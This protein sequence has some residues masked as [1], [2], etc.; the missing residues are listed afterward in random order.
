MVRPSAPRR[1]RTAVRREL[2]LRP[3]VE[4][5]EKRR[6][7]ATITV[8]G[9]GDAI[10][11]TDGQVTLREAITA[12]NGNK[13][14][15]DVVG[16]GAYGADT[17]AFNIPGAG[18]HT[19]RPT[20]ALPQITDPVT[21]D[22]YTQPGSAPNT[23]PVGQGL[24]GALLIE[25][26]GENAGDVP[27]GMIEF[28]TTDSTVRGLVI[29]RTQGVKI[30]ITN[31]GAVGHIRIEGNY[32]GTDA[33]G[34]AGFAA[35]SNPN[36]FARD[37][38]FVRTVGNTIGGT[39]PA[40][41]NLISGNIG[42][43][44][45]SYGV[46]VNAPVPLGIGTFIQGNL[47]GT[48]RTGTVALGNG[49][50]GVRGGSAFDG[51]GPLI[52]GGPEV[53]AGNLISGNGGAG[54]RI[55]NGVVQGNSIGTDITGASPLG[56]DTGVQAFGN[57]RIEQNI[58]AFNMLIAGVDNTGDGNL[59]TRNSI[60]SN[61]GPGI[62][63]NAYQNDAPPDADGI[64]NY[65]LLGSASVN[66]TGTRV[67]GTLAS[68]PSSSFRLEFFASAEREEN[69][70]EA[71]NGVFGEG[72]TF[73]GT[74]D[75]T[76]D[77]TG[78]AT[79]TADLPALPAGQPYVTATAT[80][81]TDDGAGPRNNTSPFSPIAVLGGSSFVVTNT[82]DT[83][84]GSLREA[85]DNANL[86]A[87]AQTITFAIPATD[88]H[89]V[90]YRIDG[91]SGAVTT[92]DI[93]ITTATD[94]AQ[95]ADIDPDW[96]HSWYSIRLD[97]DLPKIVD[98]IVIDGYSQPGSMRNTLPA[99]GDLDT[100]LRI[101]LDGT[102]APGNGLEL[103]FLNG[104]IDA[105][106]SQ[107]D[108]L[109]I[110]R[111]GGDGIVLDTLN[112]GNTIAGS[113]IG[114]DISGLLDRGNGGNGVALS[115]EDGATIGG[116]A[117][118]SRNL[119]SGNALSGID[120]LQTTRGLVEGNLL[121]TGRS[122]TTALPNGGDAIYFHSAVG[123]SGFQSETMSQ[124]RGA[125]DQ[126]EADKV[127]EIRRDYFR[128]INHWVRSYDTDYDPFK[129]TKMALA[130]DEGNPFTHDENGQAIDLGKPG[131]TPND[132]DNP[133]TPEID[134]D[135]DDGP[136][137]LQNYPVLT[138]ATTTR[139]STT[140]AGSLNSHVN[141]S[142]RLEFYSSSY[143]TNLFRA[144][145]H[146]LGFMDVRTDASGNASFVFTSPTL[147]P[148]GWNV[149]SLATRL[150]TGTLKPIETS[151]FSAGVAVA[152]AA[153]QALANLSVSQ[154]ATPN[155]APVGGDLIFT[156][157]V[158]NAGPGPASGVRLVVAPPA[159]ATFVA[160]T[161]GVAPAGGTLTFDLGALANGAS[162]TVTVVVRPLTP[163]TYTTSAVV[164]ASEPD[165]TPGD[166][167]SSLAVAAVDR[168]GPTIVA[169]ARFGK[170]S[171][172]TGLILTFSEALAA[173][174]AANLAGYRLLTP[175][176][177][178]KY[179]TRDDVRVRLKSAAYDAATRR[180]T[181]LTK[182]KAVLPTKFRLVVDGATGTG[183]TD[184]AGNYLDGNADGRPSD[185]FIRDLTRRSLAAPIS[186]VAAASV[187]S[188]RR[189]AQLGSQPATGFLRVRYTH[190]NL[191]LRTHNRK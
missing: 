7:L 35:D 106:H 11:A 66:G 145:E 37:G 142:F 18:V 27:F 184:L 16:V 81:V 110:N 50:G 96:A 89:H 112:G 58:I 33:S 186:V 22:G 130:E 160:A 108:G 76:S 54:V 176:R 56:N 183:P 17:I 82:G 73:L 10:N 98:T 26:D 131:V 129:A 86:T 68:K 147:V 111:F 150:E 121:G 91:V 29:N 119:I 88:P 179:G 20:S 178:K 87:G 94:D 4:A 9:A 146:T 3:E 139:G 5:M 138:S 152:D 149:I 39:T 188:T 62:G 161:G 168:T 47:I 136:N 46:F 171:K 144:G 100:V 132:G 60:F 103:R 48:D 122:T 174:R 52:V 95:I 177:D 15:S 127:N 141:T 190:G 123:S 185:D 114:T 25:I 80:D 156:V 128:T 175:G 75:V 13:N 140:I 102:N 85:I 79:F 148:A 23:N 72:R 155:P 134:P 69:S 21:I 107:I 153:A 51:A 34:T 154:S 12:A 159:G 97:R 187:K 143:D 118:G 163:G 99:L 32:I 24:N 109:A 57:V 191:S 43:F 55:L 28:Q 158:A 6:L 67:T 167:A 59:I 45:G 137:G 92:A 113:F 38:I 31:S 49:S 181:L 36:S 64:Q 30:G 166:N 93:A 77:A 78:H 165:P 182:N 14:I 151:E 19:I 125:A 116:D 162:T 41:R 63:V 61:A 2:T 90:Y 189:R 117:T 157:T 124:T 135:S 104:T 120:M 133:N 1:R 83:G 71:L 74:I 169:I 40:A 105:G 44:D 164:S 101:E 173:G 70:S 126:G 180:V 170:P 65:P 172:P 84:L 53:G 8:T 115:L 42:E